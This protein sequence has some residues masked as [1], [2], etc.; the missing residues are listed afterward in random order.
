MNEFRHAAV[1]K[2]TKTIKNT[3]Q[4]SFKFLNTKQLS[5]QRA[6]E[7]PGCDI[8]GATLASGSSKH[9]TAVKTHSFGPSDSGLSNQHEMRAMYSSGLYNAEA[10]GPGTNGS[11]MHSDLKVDNAPHTDRNPLHDGSPDYLTEYVASQLDPLNVAQ[12]AVA[13][14]V[15]QLGHQN[16]AQ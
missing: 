13:M 8:H 4:G 9:D 15:R 6:S 11:S 16:H 7:A 14:Q 2:A 1:S 10:H 12:G 3:L 5:G